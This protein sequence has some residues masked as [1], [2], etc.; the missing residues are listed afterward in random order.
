MMQW[1]PLAQAKK[2]GGHFD[3]T[4]A[5]DRRGVEEAMER[6]REEKKGEEKR[7]EER[8][9]LLR[10]EELCSL[11]QHPTLS[12]QWSTKAKKQKQSSAKSGFHCPADTNAA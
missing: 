3:Q 7:G 2:V 5:G 6:R 4:L 10:K 8:M 1:T 12:L 11:T 9:T